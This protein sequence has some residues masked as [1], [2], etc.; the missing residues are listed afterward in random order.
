VTPSL[1]PLHIPELMRAAKQ[2][3]CYGKLARS[4]NNLIYL[5]VDDAYIHQLF[6]FLKKEQI[7]KPDYFK[8]GSVGAHISVIYPEEPAVIMDKYLGKEYHFKIKELVTAEIHSKNYH[9]LLVDS[10]MLEQLRNNHDL[11]SKLNFKNYFIDFH[12]TIG[13]S[14]KYTTSS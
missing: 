14:L 7:K 11:P 9:V 12:I 5:D 4:D 10:P 8:E 1:T 13:V 3:Q 2:L 6:P